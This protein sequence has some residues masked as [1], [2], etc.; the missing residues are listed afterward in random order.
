M[1]DLKLKINSSSLDRLNTSML[2]DA[3]ANSLTTE[4]SI[5]SPAKKPSRWS[6]PEDPAI[7]IK[8]VMVRANPLATKDLGYRAPRSESFPQSSELRKLKTWNHAGWL[9]ILD[10]WVSCVGDEGLL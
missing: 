7:M 9:V 4:S 8:V 6:T 5:I 2:Q 3:S 10:D 1:R